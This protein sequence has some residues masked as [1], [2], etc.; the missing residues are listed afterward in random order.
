MELAYAF[1]ANSAAFSSDGKL[2]VEGGD[3]DTVKRLDTGRHR[4]GTTK[5]W[6]ACIDR[7]WEPVSYS[8]LVCALVCAG[9]WSRH[10]S[11]RRPCNFDLRVGLRRGLRR[12]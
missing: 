1:F 10:N 12:Q 8:R 2:S 5:T 9:S 11:S 6:K 7:N 4:P 3:F